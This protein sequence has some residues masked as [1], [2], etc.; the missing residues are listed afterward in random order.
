M[1][2]QHGAEP[3]ADFLTREEALLDRGRTFDSVDSLMKKLRSDS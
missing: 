1:P 3:I 2:V